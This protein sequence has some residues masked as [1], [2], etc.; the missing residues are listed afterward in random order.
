MCVFFSLELFI[1]CCR[2][3]EY[4]LFSITL[5]TLSRCSPCECFHFANLQFPRGKHPLHGN[6]PVLTDSVTK[7][8]FVL[9]YDSIDDPV[10]NLRSPGA[11]ESNMI[12]VFY[13][14]VIDICKLQPSSYNSIWHIVP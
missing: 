11:G 5:K 1:F 12:H 4:D 2:I 14:I 3:C 6:Y 13:C 10:R 8:L 9:L 7:S